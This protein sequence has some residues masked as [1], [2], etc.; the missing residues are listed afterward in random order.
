MTLVEEKRLNLDDLMTQMANHAETI[1]TLLQGISDEQARWKPDPEQWSILE[2]INHLG[3]EEIEDFRAHL[4]VI[5]RGPTQPWS[6]IDPQGW[7]TQRWYNQR[8][9][10]ESLARFL[11]VR[12]ASLDWLSSLDSPDW[13]AKYEAPFGQ[14][15]AGDMLASWAAHDLL[16]MRQLIELHWACTTRQATPYSVNYAGLWE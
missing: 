4:D 2:V 10:R 8:D 11:K 5:L 6:V 16:H 1:R 9:L 15:S 12:Q 3:D 13:E 7:V 14:L